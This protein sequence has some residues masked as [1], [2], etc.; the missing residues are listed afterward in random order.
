MA[1]DRAPAF[2]YYPRDYLAD[3]AVQAMSFDQQGRYWRAISL[4]WDT[5]TPGIAP[6]DQWRR[7]MAYSPSKWSANRET[8]AAAFHIP[9]DGT[10]VQKRL[11]LEKNAQRERIRRA[12]AGAKKSNELRWN[13]VA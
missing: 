8:M 6:E 1:R 10:W 2:L 7:W 11:V 9:G 3:G 12:G 4:S 5:E 13:S